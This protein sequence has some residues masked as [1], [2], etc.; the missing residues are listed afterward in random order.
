MDVRQDDPRAR[1]SEILL[2]VRAERTPGEFRGGQVGQGGE[3]LAVDGDVLV[4]HRGGVEAG[5]RRPPGSRRGRDPPPLSTAASGAGDIGDHEAGRA[6]GRSARAS[7]PDRGRSPGCR[8]PSPRP[9]CSRTVRRSRSGGAARGHLRAHRHARRRT[10]ARGIARARRRRAAR[11][12][13]GSSARPGRCR[14]CRAGGRRDGRR[15]SRARCPCRDGCARRT[16]DGLRGPGCTANDA[17]S[18]P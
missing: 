16:A 6:V 7:S 9:R 10:P 3:D 1:T 17:V 11:P 18:M 14:R 8:T 13:R 15:R 2:A 12:P 5:D 4:D